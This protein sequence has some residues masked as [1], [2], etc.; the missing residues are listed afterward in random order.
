M[1]ESIVQILSKLPPT[2]LVAV[3]VT[4]LLGGLA[5]IIYLLVQQGHASTEAM[6]TLTSNHL[7]ELPNIAE[8]LRRM[9]TQQ[10]A[11]AAALLGQLA[12]VRE[13]IAYIKARVNGKS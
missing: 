12:D 1:T 13:S 4:A 10:A 5:Y 7:H 11:L 3:L 8:T 6:D 9:E 2:A